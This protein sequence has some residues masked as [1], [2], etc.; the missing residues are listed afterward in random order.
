MLIIVYNW[1]LDFRNKIHIYKQRFFSGSMLRKPFYR[2]GYLYESLFTYSKEV[3]GGT[4]YP[5]EGRTITKTMFCRIPAEK[6]KK[7]PFLATDSKMYTI[8]II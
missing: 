2:K 4:R 1:N 7:N 3:I 8:C 6:L 5:I